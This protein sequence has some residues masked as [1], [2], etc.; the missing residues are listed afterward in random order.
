MK[1]IIIK[2]LFFIYENIFPLISWL[3]YLNDSIQGLA[4][5]KVLLA[6][7]IVHIIAIIN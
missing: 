3:T 6:T 4:M 1:S 2:L 7:K 5:H